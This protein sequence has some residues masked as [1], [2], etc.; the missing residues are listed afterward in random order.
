ME[1]PVIQAAREYYEHAFDVTHA[2]H[3]QLQPALVYGEESLW[4]YYAARLQYLIQHYGLQ[5]AKALEVGAG[6]G[7]LQHL[8]ADYTGIDLAA[9]S[10]F[11]VQKPFAAASATALPFPDNTFDLVWS[12]WVLEHV[13][14]PAAMLHEI[15]RVLKPNGLL[16]LCAAWNVP[17]WIAQ[18]YDVRSFSDFDWRGKL[19]K[20]SVMPRAN[21]VYR[22]GATLA[23]RMWRYLRWNERGVVPALPYRRLIPNFE[24]YWSSDAD[25]CTAIDSH[26]VWL[27]LKAHGDEPIGIRH[28][29]HAL[30]VRHSEPLIFRVKPANGVASI[31]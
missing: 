28:P 20:A 18:G 16:F 5:A 15:R 10:G 30:L 23:E 25:A 26:A 29:L 9:K 11:F 31:Q 19:I 24:H 7:F 12:I 2:L 8:V 3:R 4:T 14:D 1:A 22:L 13:P 6:T 27:W 17:S 21:K